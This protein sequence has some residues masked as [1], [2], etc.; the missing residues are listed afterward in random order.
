MLIDHRNIKKI[1]PWKSS[2]VWT[3]GQNESQSVF[4]IRKKEKEKDE[5]KYFLQLRHNNLMKRPSWLW[6]KMEANLIISVLLGLVYHQF[7]S[8]KKILYEELSLM[9]MFL[10]NRL[11]SRSDI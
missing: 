10:E 4:A 5:Y 1:Q 7:L 3:D 11:N 8:W 9:V 6:W 2:A